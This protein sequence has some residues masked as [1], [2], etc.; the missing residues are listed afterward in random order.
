[1]NAARAASIILVGLVSLTLVWY[2]YAGLNIV[3]VAHCAND[4]LQAASMGYVLNGE[5]VIVALEAGTP[6]AD[7]ITPCDLGGASAPAPVL[8]PGITEWR[9]ADATAAFSIDAA[10][11]GAGGTLPEA[12]RWVEPYAITQNPV[13]GLAR[14]IVAVTGLL[15][16]ATFGALAY[17][18]WHREDRLS[19]FGRSG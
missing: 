9:A 8:P 1:M 19:F 15:V 10:D 12:F 16:I 4:D 14:H 6:N 18:Q 11:V 5:T 2:G 3:R 13:G 17:T 7:G